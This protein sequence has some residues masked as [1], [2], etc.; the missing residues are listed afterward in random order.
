MELELCTSPSE[1]GFR[2]FLILAGATLAATIIGKIVGERATT[3]RKD[4]LDGINILVL[5][6]FVAAVMRDAGSSLIEMP[7]LTIGLTVAAFV[8]FFAILG[9]TFLAFAW[10]GREQAFALGFMT[11]QRNLGLMLATTGG[12]LP[13]LTWLCFAVGQFPIYL[14]PHMLKRPARWVAPSQRPAI[15]CPLTGET[16]QSHASL[17]T[18]RPYFVVMIPLTTED[19]RQSLVPIRTFGRNDARISDRTCPGSGHCNAGRRCGPGFLA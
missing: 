6:V 1:L 16:G 18:I 5:F 2:L 14:S 8:V 9:L 10:A 4:A 17:F 3:A 15:G 13:D 11:S 19:V 7:A 12:V